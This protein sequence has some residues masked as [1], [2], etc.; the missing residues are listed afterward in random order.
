MGFA[1]LD[2]SYK[3]TTRLSGFPSVAPVRSGQSTTTA[4]RWE[5]S[6]LIFHLITSQKKLIA[7]TA[8]APA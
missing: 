1:A 4:G 3:V 8:T 6:F 7:G 5:W 2:P